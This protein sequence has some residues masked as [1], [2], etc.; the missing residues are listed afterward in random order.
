M[1]KISASTT[2]KEVIT[3]QYIGLP[4]FDAI[5]DQMAGSRKDRGISESAKITGVGLCEFT[6]DAGISHTSVFIRYYDE[7]EG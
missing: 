1:P 4:I 7:N 2:G 3:I 5:I 6:D